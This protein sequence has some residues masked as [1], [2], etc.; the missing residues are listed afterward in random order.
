MEVS[1]DRV[2]EFACGS[3]SKSDQQLV[4]QRELATCR[5][6]GSCQLF[7]AFRPS[8]HSVVGPNGIHPKGSDSVPNSS[9]SRPP[10]AQSSFKSPAQ[11]KAT[12]KGK[13]SLVALSYL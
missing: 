5:Q 6:L 11:S 2:E 4:V 8:N 9:K 1:A 3:P 12:V 7:S 13:V 10:F